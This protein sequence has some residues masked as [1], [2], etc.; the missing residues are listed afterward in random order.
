MSSPSFSHRQL[1]RIASFL[2]RASNRI[3]RMAPPLAGPV[4]APWLPPGLPEWVRVEMLEA[5]KLDPLL[6]PDRPGVFH[7]YAIPHIPGP[8]QAYARINAVLAEERF[9]HFLVVPWLKRGGADLGTL[10]HANFLATQPGV[11]VLV[12]ATETADSPWAE[13]LAPE[14]RFLN[15]GQLCATLH[16]QERMQVFCRL[17]VQQ[18]PQVVHVINSE[19]GWESIHRHGLALR[20]T[21]RLFASLYCDDFTA[22][23]VPVGYA[24]S[25]LRDC[26]HDLEAVFCDNAAYPGI[27]A[28]DIGVPLHKFRV[29]YFPTEIA[30]MASQPPH[31]GTKVLWAGRMDRQKR[32]DRLAMIA[33]RL[34]HVTFDVFG[35]SLLD[36]GTADM[37]FPPNV[38]LR[39]AYDGFRSLPHSE[40]FCYLNTSDWDGLPNVLLEATA[41]GLPVVSTTVGGIGDFLHEDT[42]YAARHDEPDVVEALSQM[43]EQ[44][45]SDKSEASRRWRNA[46]ALVASRHNHDALAESLRAVDGYATDNKPPAPPLGPSSPAGD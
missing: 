11:K 7:Y 4:E 37:E 22:E 30:H 19:V 3:D 5:A 26:V 45:R 27:W 10:H 25:Y 31:Q 14:V 16:L 24:R 42:G 46:A 23:G 34:P 13:R 9:T 28:R 43:I 40:Y 35:A 41:H 33:R 44:A 21:S 6:R 8:G 29:A 36:P 18:A 32:P 1:R 20:Q 38:Q 2:R 17:V 12:V 39:G 15:F